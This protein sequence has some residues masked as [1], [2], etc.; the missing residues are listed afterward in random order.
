MALGNDMASHLGN[1]LA[2]TLAGGGSAPATF[3]AVS[4]TPNV[5]WCRSAKLRTAYAGNLFTVRRSSDNAT[6]NI[7][8]NA[9]TLA[10][11]E[12]A[13]ATFLGANSG[14]DTAW[15]DQSGN[16]RNGTQGT[17]ANQPEGYTTG[18]AVKIGTALAASFDTSNDLI[19]RTDNSG[20]TGAVGCTGVYVWST[21][22]VAAT[23]VVSILGST[24][25]ANGGFQLIAL[26]ATSITL[27]IEGASRTFTTPDLT[28]GVNKLIARLGA[29]AGV[30]TAKLRRNG[31]ELV[32]LAAVNPSNTANYVDVRTTA[33]FTSSS[34]GG[35][36]GLLAF[37][38]SAL[39]DA[40]ANLVDTTLT[41]IYGS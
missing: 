8:A 14:F 35:K 29:G 22:S 4:V 27:G 33:G 5:L 26:T 37:W 7:G 13:Q 12:A 18:T 20:I 19:Q 1:S 2:T 3:D 41:R 9:T 15:L 6:Q 40:D 32:E 28:T 21:P 31:T 30:G 24:A 34:A 11:D 10:A 25:V 36:L 38:A 23:R 39:S 17:A 16:A